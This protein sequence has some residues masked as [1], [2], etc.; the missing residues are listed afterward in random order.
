MPD[1]TMTK[2]IFLS[3]TREV[4]WSFLT[5]QDKLAQWFHPSDGPLV[6]GQKYELREKQSDGSFHKVCWGTVVSMDKP[7]SMEW[8]FTV[9]PLNGAMT[10]VNWNLE[11]SN[12]GT[13]LTMTHS[14]IDEAAGE[15][16]LGLLLA[17]DKGWDEHFASLRN[18]TVAESET[19]AHECA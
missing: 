5:E 19:A 15:A 17:L 11:A 9:G 14:G 2:T 8:T 7:N 18:A 10:S 13:R 1:S 4:V 16:A 6:E 12:G 3:T